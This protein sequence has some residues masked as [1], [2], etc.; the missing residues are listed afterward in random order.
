MV[1]FLLCLCKSFVFN[2]VRGYHVYKTPCIP[3]K[4]ERLFSHREPDNLEDKYAWK[5][6]NEIVEHLPLGR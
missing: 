4:G 2:F 3:F 5:K 1:F 6:E